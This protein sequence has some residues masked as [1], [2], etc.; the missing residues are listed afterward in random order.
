M[1]LAPTAQRAR[2]AASILFPALLLALSGLNAAA[3]SLTFSGRQIPTGGQ[4]QTTADFNGDGRADIATAGLDLE[5]LL[6]NGNA[7]FQPNRKFPIG[8]SMS[9]IAKGDFNSDQKIDIAV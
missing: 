9:G 8:T 4:Y 2:L 7:T 3:Q 5:I 1:L 6:G